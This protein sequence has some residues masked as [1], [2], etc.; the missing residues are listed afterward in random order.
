M[1]DS[2]CWSRTRQNP[3]EAS[4]QFKQQQVNAPVLVTDNAEPSNDGWK[5]L[6]SP[7]LTSIAGK[8]SG[9]AVAASISEEI[10]EFVIQVI[11]DKGITD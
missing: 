8:A 5:I 3:N 6:T 10:K 9:T 4:E 7:Y 2:L 1:K 11:N